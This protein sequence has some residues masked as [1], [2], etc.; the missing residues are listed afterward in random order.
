MVRFPIV[1]W[2]VLSTAAAVIA[3]LPARA[4][5]ADEQK[6]VLVLYQPRRD[7]Q[8]V[9]VGDRELP[10]LLGN[11]LPGGVDYYSEALDQSRFLNPEY[12]RAFR[13]SLHL[14]YERHRFDLV[15]AVGEMPLTF[16]DRNRELLFGGAPIVFFANDAATRR[17][18]NSTGIIP[19]LNLHDTVL[20]ADALQP[21]LRQVY[22]IASADGPYEKPA[23]EQFEP[24]TSR[25]AFTYFTGLKT[26]DLEA[27]LAS[28]PP[29]SM[30]YYLNVERDG[31]DQNFRP[32]DY[33]DH[34]AA[35]ANAPT[36][37]WVDSTMN[38]G[39]V[40][41]SLKDQVAQM[42]ALGSLA[43]RVLRGEPADSIPVTSPNLNVTQVDWRQL[44]RWDISESL[45]PAGTVVR[46]REPT[47]WERYRLYIIGALGAFLVETVLI[48]GLLI[49][50][51]RRRQ[52]EQRAL[53]S[54]ADLRR[55][56]DRIR[57]LG[58]RLLNE[59]EK[60]R[61]RIARELH[62]DVSQ[63]VA[64]LEMDLERLNAGSAS[65]PEGFVGDTLIR[66]RS[67]GRSL[68]D[69]SHRL[70]PAH[71]RLIGLVAAVEGLQRE[72]TSS[73]VPL[74]FTYESVPPALP[75]DL[76]FCIFRIVQESV[77]NALKH[78]GARAVEV[79]LRGDA[80]GLSLSVVDDGAGFDVEKAWG[81]GLGLIS[82]SERVEALGGTFRIRSAA[83]TGTQVDVSV[84]LPPVNQ[85]ETAAV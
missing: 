72:L 51:T 20:L 33:L 21:G 69:L 70:H 83:V 37:S 23:R 9:V 61:A 53:R 75:P 1:P 7:S 2:F 73:G 30:V 18:P 84:P 15:I 8:V 3:G 26:R 74:T 71:L 47:A 28:L 44:Q 66:A 85:A 32:L 39:V 76:T 13:D 36:Y 55:S 11:G 52:A 68:R 14:K 64:V 80:D 41:G 60:E 57:D 62:D 63:Q 24:L 10:P 19:E 25:F 42:R 38:H 81:K 65:C 34:I 29:H 35:V 50:R 78:S 43:V 45:V 79:R 31:S 22:V 12:Q 77:H 46:F 6:R 17:P 40:G 4:W 54:E 49:Q 59:Q 27:Q 58:G 16:V 48:A 82:M 56:F 5:S 67:I